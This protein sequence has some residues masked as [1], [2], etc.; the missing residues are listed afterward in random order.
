MKLT[1]YF[2][3]CVIFL[4]NF[5]N[6]QSSLQQK[7]DNFTGFSGFSTGSISLMAMDVSTGGT[8][9]EYNSLTAL[10]SASTMK[11][12][13]TASAIELLGPNYKAKT[14]LF[15]EGTI[16]SD[17]TLTGNIW[18]IGGGDMTL[19]SKYFNDEGKQTDFLL[20]WS[21]A[22]RKAGI[23]SITG[24]II[25]DASKFGYEGAPD[26]WNWSDMGN[27]YGA[28]FSGLTV[29]DNM[30]NYHFKTSSAGRNAQLISTFPIVENFIFHNYIES[31]NVRGDDSYIY[32]APYSLDRFGT[33]KLPAN[34]A[35]FMVKGSL[36]DPEF[37]VATELHKTLLQNGIS[38]NGLPIAKRHNDE[39]KSQSNLTLIKDFEGK[40]VLEIATITN[41][42][43]INLFAEGLLCSVGFNKT[44]NG[45]SSASCNYIESYW[46]SKFNTAG[47]H[48]NDGS[49]LSRTN[50]V[51]ASHY[52]L[53]LKNMYDSKNYA[54]FL[55]TLPIAG[56]SGTLKNVCRNQ[57]AH[58][59]L[60]A[61]SGTMN[62]I[63]SYSGY[64]ETKTGKI[65]AV[66][67]IVN[68][69]SC[70]NSTV[71]DEMEK[72]FNALAEY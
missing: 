72:V 6:G 18:I 27:Y 2:F 55:S 40:S 46:S 21:E 51:S 59:R 56:E 20:N 69:Y 43:S 3:I 39:L 32:G 9:I 19:G 36:P 71:V 60:K 30:L 24:S 12:F 45:S 50:A 26:G 64:I 8:V 47:L 61:K 13:S 42:K 7:L 41:H 15:Y 17:S 57:A 52:C 33:G 37:Q 11:L 35:D 70:S 38:V 1:R 62:R 23:K 58:G 28:G 44:G 22:I 67:I 29:F 49:G 48:I 31:A 25:A 14:S 53:L 54:T 10:P 5:V 34:T 66:A 68:N 16:S 4:G 63:K 65:L